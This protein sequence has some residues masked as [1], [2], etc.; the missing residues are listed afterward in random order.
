[1][2]QL[3]ESRIRGAEKLQNT[4]ELIP[5]LVLLGVDGMSDDESEGVDNDERDPRFLI[6][7][8]RCRNPELNNWLKTFSL[9][10]KSNKWDVLGNAKKGRFMRVRIESDLMAKGTPVPGLP[11]N[12]YAEEFRNGLTEFETEEMNMQ[13][14]VPIKHTNHALE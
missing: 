1:M 8:P 2:K 9:I 11:I 10:D 6:I 7:R 5:L 12:W 3:L 14:P 13:P 4:R